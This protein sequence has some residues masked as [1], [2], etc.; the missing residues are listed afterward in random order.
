MRARNIIALCIGLSLLSTVSLTFAQTD[1]KGRGMGGWGM[2]TKFQRMYNPATAETIS[3]TVE[4]VDK[5]SPMKGMSHGVHLLV[6][7]DKEAIPVHLG[8][9]WYVEKLDTK[10]ANGDKVE[11][12]GS[13]VTMGGKPVIIAAEVKKNGATIRLRDEKGIPVWAGKRGR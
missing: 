6:K 12:T 5:V 3:G 4:S 1:G 7:T 9:A 8:P 13:R 11:V 10:I 2:G